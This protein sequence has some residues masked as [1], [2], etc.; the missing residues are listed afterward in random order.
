[1]PQDGRSG[2]SGRSGQF[3]NGKA[4]GL[5]ALVFTLILHTVLWAVFCFALGVTL[6]RS[7]ELIADFGII[8]SKLAG[9]VVRAGSSLN[10]WF[11]W[12][13]LILDVGICLLAHTFGGRR[14]LRRWTMAAAAGMVGVLVLCLH[15]VA[16]PIQRMADQWTP[17]VP[18]AASTADSASH[19][20]VESA[21]RI[22]EMLKA[23]HEAGIATPLELLDAVHDLD[24]AEARA[25]HSDAAATAATLKWSKA[26]M[27]LIKARH[28]AGVATLLD[29]LDARR[30]LAVA[31]ARTANNPAGAAAAELDWARAK[32]ELLSR[33]Y[34]AGNINSLE[35]ERA[36]ADLRRA[37]SQMPP[38]APPREP[39]PPAN[40]SSPPAHTPVDPL[41]EVRGNPEPVNMNRQIQPKK[42]PV[43]QLPPWRRAGHHWA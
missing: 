5:A 38:A 27:E 29:V 28:G 25:A 23:R 22:Y 42:R 8:P 26:R 32:L 2:L 33:Q 34:E 16:A 6:Q 9:D 18:S 14:G 24:V 30:D 36:K 3:K 4:R 43:P 40:R 10:G 13:L 1:M 35:V 12:G 11:F 21:R 41:P 37:E 7:E 19:A 20:D 15:E 39:Q 31:E 17:P